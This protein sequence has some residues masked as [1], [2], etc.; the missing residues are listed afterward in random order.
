MKKTARLILLLAT[1]A[2]ASQDVA[3]VTIAGRNVALWKPSGTAPNAGYPLVLFSHG[4]GGC[5]TQSIFL[6]EALAQ[7][8]YFVLAPN[9][10]DAGCGT[11]KQDEQGWY[12]GKLLGGRK[13]NARPEVPFRDDSQWTDQTYKDRY[14]DIE[15]VLDAALRDKSFKGIAIDRTR[16]GIAGHSLGGYTA[17]GMA[18]AWPSWKDARI[19]AVLALA[20]YNTPYASK[21]DLAHLNVPVM[22]QGGTRDLGVTPTVKRFNGA[23]DHSSKPKYYVE[24]DGAGHFAWTNLKSEHHDMINKYSLAFFDHYLKGKTSPDPLAPLVGNPAPQG[25]SYLKVDAKP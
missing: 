13:K 15:A 1:A 11:A 14:A 18:G 7:S 3:H 16:I 25:V 19:K 10:K 9:H 17:L 4:F 21:G 23:Y 5:N 22:Y 2:Y 24:F 20:A 6:M 8:G 12:P